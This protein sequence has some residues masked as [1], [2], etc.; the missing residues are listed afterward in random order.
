[1][2]LKTWKCEN[3][4][5]LQSI[6]F[7]ITG[8]DILV[9]KNNSG[10]SNIVGSLIDYR[11]IICNERTIDDQWFNDRLTAKS[12]CDEIRFSATYAISD[13]DA[14]RIS[15]SLKE[16]IAEDWVD[17]HIHANLDLSHELL[18]R[19]HGVDSEIKIKNN[20]TEFVLYRSEFDNSL[21]R[22]QIHQMDLPDSQVGF[23]DKK[24][25]DLDDFESFG[26]GSPNSVEDTF[27]EVMLPAG[28]DNLIRS[29]LDRWA[30]IDS[31]RKATSSAPVSIKN[32]L[33]SDGDN[34][35]QVLHTLS[36]NN[37]E[38]FDEISNLYSEIMDGVEEIRAPLIGITDDPN[39]TVKIKEEGF[40]QFFALE[41]ISSG[42]QEILIL[43]TKIVLAG[44]KSKFLVVEEPELHLHPDAQ[45]E[46]FEKMVEIASD[47][48]NLIVSTHSNTF[49]E[50]SDSEDILAITRNVSID[51]ITEVNRISGENIDEHL[52]HMGFNK[53]DVF[54]SNAVVFVEGPSD[55]FVLEEF[56]QIYGQPVTDAGITLIPAGGDELLNHGSEVCDVLDRLRIPYMIIA[57]SDGN[58]TSDVVDKYNTELGVSPQNVWVLEREEIESYLLSESRPV[59][60]VLNASETQVDEFTEERN[61]NKGT[62]DQLFRVHCNGSQYNERHHSGLIAKHY[63]ST[64][65][66]P[67]ITEILS[68]I[69]GLSE[70][71]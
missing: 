36:Q 13:V 32:Q 16:E 20:R 50:L 22:V 12:S 1:M 30:L 71:T 9:G 69:H 11:S 68:E 61:L 34:L 48:T 43:I 39:T 18:I 10:K 33:R 21:G 52:A 38:K 3:Y 54:Q 23:E 66:P 27:F 65:L 58:E 56:S 25:S 67:E 14:R 57:D 40:D 59:A 29:I 55:K 60:A 70:R 6:E 28:I 62:L 7:E 51:G 17:R 19:D 35:T 5:T 42:S 49:V 45:R 37:P 41:S 47:G 64:E 4:K 8:I 2:Q 53:A 26:S 24:I 15:S 44:E 46:L 31:F 63:K